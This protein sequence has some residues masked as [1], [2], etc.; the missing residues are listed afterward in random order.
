MHS[1]S[2]DYSTIKNRNKKVS[3]EAKSN[4]DT[5]EVIKQKSFMEKQQK[6]LEWHQYNYQEL[7]PQP[8]R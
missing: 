4:N 8:L 3:E 7:Q 2:Q 5:G 6:M 1:I